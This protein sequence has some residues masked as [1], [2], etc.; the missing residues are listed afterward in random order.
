MAKKESTQEQLAKLE[1]LRTGPL[2]DEA[3]LILQKSL[4]S[5]N[6]AVVA[7]ASRLIAEHGF[8]DLSPQ[9]VKAFA[10]FMDKPERKDKACLAKTAII[11]TLDQLGYRDTDIFRQGTRH[12][13][14]E[15]IFGGHED[16]AANLRA[17]SALALARLDDEDLFFELPALLI[18]PEAAAR[19]AA[20]KALIYF[21]SEK[22][23]LLLRLKALTGDREQ[24]IFSE[25][26]AGL[27]L[28]HPERS[29]DFVTSFLV[30]S[31]FNVVESAAL[32]LGESRLPQAFHILH[33][34]WENSIDREFKKML[35]LP[36]ALIRSGVS[37][38]F[39]CDVLHDEY[40]EYAV[41][42]LLAL[43]VYANDSEQRETIRQVVEARAER[44]ISDVYEREY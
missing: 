15:P 30:S 38:D 34:H 7:K 32:A 5:S 18:D 28:I 29:L 25:C 39:L 42:A 17:Q 24:Q 11:E 1:K 9:L 20:V 13:Q 14:L 44:N 19:L 3:I 16:T 35:L 36:M 22:S 12:V 23:E 40:V 8:S 43:K 26:L 31:D 27:M 2:S 10:R 21:S 4:T 33:T 6:N 41:A 37:F